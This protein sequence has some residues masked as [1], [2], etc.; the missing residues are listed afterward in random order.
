M[1]ERTRLKETQKG[2]AHCTGTTERQAKMKCIMVNRPSCYWLSRIPED[3]FG[4][5]QWTQTTRGKAGELSGKTPFEIQI[6]GGWKRV[7]RA[8]L[9]G[10]ARWGRGERLMDIP[11]LKAKIGT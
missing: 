10:Q 7:V 9:R 3:C 8:S 11:F 2:T 1:G 5:I 4:V 6:D